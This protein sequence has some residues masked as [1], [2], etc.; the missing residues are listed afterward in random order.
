MQAASDKADP[1]LSPR[2]PVVSF[3]DE[4]L[5]LVDGDD[6]ILGY[7]SKDTCHDGEG[8]LHR[9]FSVFLFD[10]QGR[11]LLQQR[12]AGKRLWSLFWANACCSHPRR[13]E[14]TEAA[15][16]RRAREELSATPAE[17]LYLFKF[18]YHARFGEAGSE[19]EL[20]W[21]FAGRWDEAIAPNA[22]EVAAWKRVEPEELDRDIDAHPEHY[23]PWLK[24]EWARM[25]SEFWPRIKTLWETH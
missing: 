4:P 24:M 11:V 22:N 8:R 6:A 19:H 3:D 21:V 10:S 15:A 2:D 20:C 7:G 12:A 1:T 25:R 17:L 16:Y 14:E 5:I 23:T 18:E 9:A 13:G